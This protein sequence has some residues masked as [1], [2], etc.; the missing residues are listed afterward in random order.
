MRNWFL[1]CYCRLSWQQFSSLPLQV[2]KSP[3]KKVNAHTP[4][5]GLVRETCGFPHSQSSTLAAAPGM[6][7]RFF[8]V[9]SKRRLVAGFRFPPL[10]HAAPTA[11][12][13]HSMLQALVFNGLTPAM[14]RKKHSGLPQISPRCSRPDVQTITPSQLHTMTASCPGP[15]RGQKL[16]LD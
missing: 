16:H 6:Y 2:I 10:V 4:I 5:V 7:M 13:G 9:C 14:A 11:A 15:L 12:C 1:P 3:M 8:V